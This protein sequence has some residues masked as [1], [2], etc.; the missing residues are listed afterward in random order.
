MLTRYLVSPL[1]KEVIGRLP[2]VSLPQQTSWLSTIPSKRHS[3]DIDIESPLIVLTK[4]NISQSPWKMRFLVK[5][6]KIL[7]YITIYSVLG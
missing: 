6:V 3:S 7:S 1:S 2:R 4:D 5:L